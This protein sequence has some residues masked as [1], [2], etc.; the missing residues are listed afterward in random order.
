M[1][2]LAGILLTLAELSTGIAVNDHTS[3]HD[4]QQGD[5]FDNVQQDDLFDDKEQARALLDGLLED[6]RLYKKSEDYQKLLDFVIHLRNFAPFNA[7]LLQIQKPGLS[8]AASA[9]DW[10]EKFKRRPK[11]DARPLLI[12]W[13]FGP[14]ALVYDV[15]DTEGEPLPEDTAYFPAY[16]DMDQQRIN[17]FATLLTKKGVNWVLFDAGDRNAGSISVVMRAENKR[18]K[19]LYQIKINQNHSPA[20]QFTTLAHELGHLFLGHLGRDKKLNI[21]QRRPLTLDQRE[22]EAES[23]AYIVCH[24]QGIHPKSQTYLSDFVKSDSG[25]R[26]MDFYQVMRA[27]G[28]VETILQLTAHAKF[29]R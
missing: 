12:L 15:M 28:G 22:I 18:E 9:S 14:V 23:V 6:S 24:R 27:A 5:L 8:Y 3:E 26:D 21:P 16:G 25:V 4:T 7:M 20:V 29:D 2:C 10:R 17:R 13:P 19:T 11:D 1:K